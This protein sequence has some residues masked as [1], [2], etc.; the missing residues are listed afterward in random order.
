MQIAVIGWGSLIWHPGC[1]RTKSRWYSDGPRLPIEFARISSDK[2]LTL[3]I[4]LGSAAQRTYWAV[5]EFKTLS[6]VRKNLGKR[7]GTTNLDYVHALTVGG[8]SEGWKGVVD[9]TV[10]ERIREWL[11]GRQEIQGA[12]WTGLATNWLEKRGKE[13]TPEDALQYLDDVERAKDNATSAYNRTR[14]YITNTP[15]RIQT[16]VRKMVRKRK[17]WKDAVLAGIL[18]EVE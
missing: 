7:E 12:V 1:L 10:S 16:V 14:E 9:A 8:R 15:P 6:G 5:S 11:K 3:V 18:F 4:H 17:G 2:R 13:F